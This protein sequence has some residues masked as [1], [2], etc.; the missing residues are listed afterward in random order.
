ML[1]D[2]DLDLVMALVDPDSLDEFDG[3]RLHDEELVV[4]AALNHP[5]ARAKQVRVHHLARH[6]LVTSGEGSALRDTLLT[7]VP[8]GRVVAEANDL[9]TVCEL[10]ALGLGVTLMPRA[11]VSSH[12]D[13]LA[14]RP[15]K[16]RR[17]LPFGLVW[18]M[19][20]HPTP[21]AHAFREHVL[22]TMA[23]SLPTA[24]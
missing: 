15:L 22:S 7:L 4:I 6:P 21:A 5:L 11:A 20:E 12:G 10:A 19:G 14:I 24:E 13:R 3:V 23:G 2:G 8:D 9:E 17:V 1:R 16:P 18:R